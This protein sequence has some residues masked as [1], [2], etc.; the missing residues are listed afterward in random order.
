MVA[1]SEYSDLYWL[2]IC[3]YSGGGMT[4]VYE[5][6]TIRSIGVPDKLSVPSDHAH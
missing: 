2:V 4:K 1:A 6:W 3:V 5:F